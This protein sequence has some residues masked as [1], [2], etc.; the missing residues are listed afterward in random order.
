MSDM[1]KQELLKLISKLWT[2]QE[3]K[4]RMNKSN[5]TIHNWRR[6]RGLP[7]IEI[8]GDVRSTIRF[9]PNEV[10]AWARKHGQKLNAA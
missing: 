9:V 2:V 7:Y 5:M 4:R 6:E 3:L 1:E 8:K 10:R